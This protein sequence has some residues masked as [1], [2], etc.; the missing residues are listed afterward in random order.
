MHRRDDDED[1]VDDV[2]DS[3]HDDDDETMLP[4]TVGIEGPRRAVP[5]VRL[6]SV[7]IVV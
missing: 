7:F 3:G 1:I 2:G 4:T 6:V 5:R